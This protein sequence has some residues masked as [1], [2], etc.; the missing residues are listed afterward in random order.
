MPPK[1]NPNAFAGYRILIIGDAILDCYQYGK[2]ERISREAPVPIVTNLSCSYRCGGAANTAANI[3]ALGSHAKLV[4]LCGE[5]ERRKRLQDCCEQVGIETE[6]LAD[7][8]LATICKTRILVSG[9]QLIRLDD[10]PDH[11]SGCSQLGAAVL[12]QLSQF[13]AIVLSDYGYNALNMGRQII[14][15]AHAEN[16]KV[17]VDPRGNDWSRYTGADLVTPNLEEF[18]IAA[19]DIGASH[20]QRATI[21][22]QKHQ[23]KAILLTT[24]EQGMTLFTS[25]HAP[26]QLPTRKVEVFD[27]TGAGDTVIAMMALGMAAGADL[28]DAAQWANIAAGIV[29]TKLG[30]ASVSSSELAAPPSGRGAQILTMPKLQDRLAADRLAGKSVVMTNG[31]FDIFHAGHMQS[32]AAAARLGDILIVAINDDESIKKIKGNDRPVIPLDERMQVLAGLGCVDY[33]VAF[34]TPD[35]VELV[36][37]IRPNIYV[38][39]EDWAKNP[40]PEAKLVEQQGGAVVYQS[41]AAHLSTTEI[42]RRIKTDTA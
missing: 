4:A 32:L 27:T 12:P 5:D 33:V 25:D 19:P 37:T 30:T 9:Q 7:P 17:V 40:P 24:G 18:Q 22:M 28:A 11:Q 15:A 41:S 26:Q 13:Q 31:C 20:E 8:N 16:I 1:L 35:A 2:T 36:R 3:T 6:L 14:A 21:L 34:T 38:K 42:I 39:G 29:V 23:I 10:S